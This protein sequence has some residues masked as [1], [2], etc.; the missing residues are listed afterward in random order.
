VE[1]T[2]EQRKA[3]LIIKNYLNVQNNPKFTDDYILTQFDLAVDELIESA[4]TIKSLKTIG[5]KSVSEGNQTM[6]FADNVEAWTITSNIKMLLPKPFVR[7]L[8]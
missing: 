1:L 4:N 2:K 8:G 3:I 7:F 6:T 5:V